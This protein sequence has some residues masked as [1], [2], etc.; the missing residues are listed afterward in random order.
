MHAKDRDNYYLNDQ[1]VEAAPVDDNVVKT[2]QAKAEIPIFFRYT[3]MNEIIVSITYFHKKNSFFN[4]KDLKIKISP[5][6]RHGKFVNFK[7]LFEKY[8]HHCKNNFI[9]QIPSL[10]KQKFLQTRETLKGGVK[11]AAGQ[12]MGRGGASEYALEDDDDDEKMEG[13]KEV[14]L[15][16]ARKIMF[17]EYYHD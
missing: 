15:K 13:R 12:V 4:S 7:R 16:N 1:K 5:F 6:I 11:Q 8:E 3:R 9:K 10:I 14:K 17:G 2:D